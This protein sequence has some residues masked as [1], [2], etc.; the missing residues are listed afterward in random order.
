MS[1]GAGVGVVGTPS[2]TM[3]IGTKSSIDYAYWAS[4][5][6]ADGSPSDYTDIGPETTGAPLVAWSAAQVGITVSSTWA[7]LVSALTTE[8]T[9]DY[10]LRTRGAMLYSPTKIAVSLG[11]YDVIDIVNGR[12]FVQRLTYASAQAK[13]SHGLL[14]PGATY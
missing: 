13:W 11:L 6:V 10:A 7:I 12:Y 2:G 3:R 14:L 5:F 1:I 9:V 4:R 8:V